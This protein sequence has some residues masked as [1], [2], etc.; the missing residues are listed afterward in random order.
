MSSEASRKLS[1]RPTI[2]AQRAAADK[3]S[4][5]RV[6]RTGL[7]DRLKAGV[8][9][10]SGM[11]LDD[12]RVHRNSSEPAQL[13]AHAF[14]QGSDIHLAPGQDHHLPHEAWHVVQQK[15]GRVRAT[16]QLKSGV[17]I[18]DDAGLEHEADV[19]GARAAATIG[20]GDG[21]AHAAAPQR[22]PMQRC[23]D[24]ATLLIEDDNRT[25]IDNLLAYCDTMTDK[26]SERASD[27][28]QREE[29]AVAWYKLMSE[30]E[31]LKTRVTK[32][33]TPA[34][35]MPEGEGRQGQYAALSE[36]L[37]DGI[38][39]L[40]VEYR[41]LRDPSSS[42]SSSGTKP[43]SAPHGADE[44]EEEE[45]ESASTGPALPDLQTLRARKIKGNGKLAKAVKKKLTEYCRSM[46][47]LTEAMLKSGSVA[48][49]AQIKWQEEYAKLVEYLGNLASD[50]KESYLYLALKGVI[51]EVLNVQKLADKGEI[52]NEE[53]P[54][55]ILGAL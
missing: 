41:G 30:W 5:A 35:E 34:D 45:K 8:E 23:V 48:L 31:T 12:V 6:N 7:P 54:N 52:C 24:P 1:A 26:C 46:I 43:A 47:G 53:L 9:A 22:A 32:F 21:V 40:N 33:L 10:L 39:E 25:S 16:R 19:M 13:Q 27:A 18:N 29:P 51:A 37:V 38:E 17:A 15:Q 11:S 50:D 44:E 3:L 20:T 55:N 4:T 28:E 14:A 2:V 36:S 49:N 42:S